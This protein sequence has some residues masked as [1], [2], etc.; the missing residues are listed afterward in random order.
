[1]KSGLQILL[2]D[3]EGI[4]RRAV[5]M[6]LEHDGHEVWAVDCGEAALDHLAKRQFDLLIT[7]FFMPG[8]HGRQLVA[9]VRQLVPAQPI[10]IATAFP[11]E[12]KASGQ[13]PENSDT[14]LLKP[15]SLDDLRAAIEQVL[16]TKQTPQPGTSLPGT[17]LA[18]P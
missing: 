2:V 5:K 15:F 18:L 3:D 4:V 16:S 8:L 9:R 10:I 14:L 17:G 1:M 12:S 6:L 7:D 13:P 11:E